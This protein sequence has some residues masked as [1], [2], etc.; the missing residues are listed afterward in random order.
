MKK[1][2]AAQAE[3]AAGEEGVLAARAA[4]RKADFT[5]AEAARLETQQSIRA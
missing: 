5:A 4:A 2:L 3:A 1:S